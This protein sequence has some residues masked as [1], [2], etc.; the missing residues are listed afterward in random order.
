[1]KVAIMT[2]KRMGSN[3]VEDLAQSWRTR[4][5]PHFLDS[6]S[7]MPAPPISGAVGH[8]SQPSIIANL[9]QLINAYLLTAT[10]PPKRKFDD[11]NDIKGR[12]QK[13]IKHLDDFPDAL[14]LS[15]T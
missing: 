11:S 13:A 8:N 3:R 10:M 4:A 14:V 15:V 6:W 12:I 2:R 5:T 1:V 7:Q 9:G